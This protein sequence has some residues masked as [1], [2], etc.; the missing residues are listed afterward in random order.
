MDKLS[1]KDLDYGELESAR[2]LVR[3]D[4]N[5]PIDS[6]G[7]VTD[8]TRIRSALPT[9]EFLRERG[10]GQVL[11]SH[12]GRPKGKRDASL[13]LAPVS[14]RLAELTGWSVTFVEEPIGDGALERVRRGDRSDVFLLE[15]IRFYPGEEANDPA[16]AQ[17]LAGLADFY[18]NDAFGTAHRAH[19]STVGVTRHLAP[20]VAGLLMEMEIESLSRALGSPERPFVV[21]IGGAKIKG[22]IDVIR[23]LFKR[24]DSLLV[25]GAMANTFFAAKDYPVGE[26]L[27]D[28]D[29]IGTARSL[30]EEAKGAGCE[31]VLPADC[32]IARERRE[33]SSTMVV[34]SSAVPT[35][36]MAVDIGPMTRENF[37]E[38]IL[39]SNT[40]VWN[41]P[42]G[43]FE[44]DP[45]AD[46]TI[47]VAQSVAEATERGAFSLL[48]GG[49]SVAAVRR[50]G[51]EKSIS[52]IS[53]GG[54]ASLEFLAGNPL[55][56]VEALSDREERK[57][58]VDG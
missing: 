55:P 6:S 14:L 36:W 1:V 31:L 52:H 33:G 44:I 2:A 17:A 34:P 7:K 48:G 11:V 49:D 53:T 30:I 19:A 50:A 46:G 39:A 38:K 20:A 13:S 29:R 5:V 58:E 15:N 9:M 51:L 22:K 32:V 40:I 4:F 45:F 21:I 37:A 3:V 28:T 43:V 35:G 8:D 47:A 42:M 56:G 23:N 12:L 16:F 10:I 25:G 57:T 18:V 41:G 24:V 26:S 54:G 27:V